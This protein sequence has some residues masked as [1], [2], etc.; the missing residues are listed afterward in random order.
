MENLTDEFTF[1]TE[2]FEG[3]GKRRYPVLI[4]YDV[5]STKRRNKLVKLLKRYA[6]RVQRSAFECVIDKRLFE[7][8]LAEI[9]NFF[10]PG[11]LIRVYRLTSSA[12]VKTWGNIGETEY[13]EVIV[14]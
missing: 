3:G 8:L 4:I 7:K 5:S 13:E 9:D 6:R 1:E 10:N 14:I 2:E 11:D 12:D